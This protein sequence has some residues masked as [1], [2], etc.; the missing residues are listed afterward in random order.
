MSNNAID[1][2]KLTRALDNS[3]NNGIDNLNY[4]T[5]ENVK[6]NIINKLY[7]SDE[8]SDKMKRSLQN[9]RYIDELQELKY[10]AYIRYIN[11]NNMENLYLNKGGF[12][13]SIEIENNGIHIRCRS[14]YKKC[15]FE[16][17]F[18]EVLI[19]QKITDQ[20]KT[21]LDVL[22]LLNS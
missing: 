22:E 7:L 16:I 20:E 9:Y 8:K 2:D 1:I 10:G 19:F 21:I 15:F 12:I 3:E 18:D 14:G 17:K 11:L 13:Y 5:I 4:T 6:N